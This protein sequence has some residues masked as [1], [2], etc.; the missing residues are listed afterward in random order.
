MRAPSIA[1][2]ALATLLIA[3][4]SVDAAPHGKFGG[5]LSGFN[6]GF[7]NKREDA[8]SLL[9]KRQAEAVCPTEF[10]PYTAEEGVR[11]GPLIYFKRGF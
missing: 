7:L 10:G 1:V 3:V 8:G 9:E 4:S 6:F 11:V 2:L 5:F